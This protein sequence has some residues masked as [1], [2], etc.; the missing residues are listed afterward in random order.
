[1]VNLNL[2]EKKNQRKRSITKMERNEW[3]EAIKES[4]PVFSV[5]LLGALAQMIIDLPKIHF[6]WQLLIW[7]GL[8]MIAMRLHD[9]GMNIKN[10]KK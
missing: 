8:Y 5:F 10:G 7:C 4:L 2:L 6:V 9:W 3:R 1:M